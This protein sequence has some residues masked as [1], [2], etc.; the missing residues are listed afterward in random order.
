MTPQQVLEM[1]PEAQAY[2]VFAG[3]GN[4]DTKI[5]T[6]ML[7]GGALIAI[8][9]IW[10]NSRESRA[11][12]TRD[13]SPLREIAKIGYIAGGTLIGT[14]IGFIAAVVCNPPMMSLYTCTGLLIGA[15]VGLVFRIRAN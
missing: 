13:F 10:S 15:V 2:Y 6:M 14:A 8:M 9:A 7:V 4:A 5:F 11:Q 1:L 12:P 3:L